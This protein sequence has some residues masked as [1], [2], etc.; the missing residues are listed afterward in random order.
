MRRKGSLSSRDV[1]VT[2]GYR[3][4]RRFLYIPVKIKGEWRWWETAYILQWHCFGW[5]N[6]QWQTVESYIRWR[7][8][9]G[10][11]VRETQ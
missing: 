5:Y 11:K 3:V 9:A 8:H 1:D 7:K 10:Y 4:V 6:V 2:I